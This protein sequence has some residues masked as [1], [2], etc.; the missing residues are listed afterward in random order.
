MVF[1]FVFG[2][3]GVSKFFM[4]DALDFGFSAF[5]FCVQ[6]SDETLRFRLGGG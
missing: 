2:R 1:S 6:L 5:F 4:F 3:K